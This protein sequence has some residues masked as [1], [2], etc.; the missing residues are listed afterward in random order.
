MPEREELDVMQ[1]GV[2]KE[3]APPRATR[4]E[5]QVKSVGSKPIKSGSQ[6]A[7]AVRQ[8]VTTGSQSSTA[9]GQHVNTDH[10]STA[11]VEIDACS[12]V[13]LMDFVDEPSANLIREL[14][15]RHQE[16]GQAVDDQS[17]L[18]GEAE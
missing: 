10:L 13:K 6:S 11:P 12:L 18:V 9:V 15:R 7:T 2:R 4:W 5:K 1:T 3:G 8:H 17:S 14:L 16:M